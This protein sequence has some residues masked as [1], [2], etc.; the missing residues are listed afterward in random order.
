MKREENEEEEK[1]KRRLSLK[2]INW[3]CFFSLS[4]SSFPPRFLIFYFSIL[5][6]LNS[7][8]KKYFKNKTFFFIFLAIMLKVIKIKF[9]NS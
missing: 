1:N 8:N 7:K 3:L 4:L 2:Q 5:I 9:K 6:F